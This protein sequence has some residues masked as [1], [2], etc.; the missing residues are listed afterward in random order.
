MKG[1]F[2]RLPRV[3]VFSAESSPGE[4]FGEAGGAE[5]GLWKSYFDKKLCKVAGLGS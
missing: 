2:T 4:W 5:Q 3:F 1:R